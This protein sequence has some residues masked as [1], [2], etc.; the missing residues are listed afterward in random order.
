MIRETAFMAW[1]EAIELVTRFTQQQT[2]V[3]DGAQRQQDDYDIDSEPMMCE[4]EPRT[5]EVQEVPTN[6]EESTHWLMNIEPIYP[7]YEMEFDSEELGQWKTT[8]DLQSDGEIEFDE[9]W[10]ELKDDMDWGDDYTTKHAIPSHTPKVQVIESLNIP[11]VNVIV[12]EPQ[13][14]QQTP[15]NQNRQ[16]TVTITDTEQNHSNSQTYTFTQGTATETPGSRS[17]RWNRLRRHES[18]QPNRSP[19]TYRLTTAPSNGNMK[20]NRKQEQEL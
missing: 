4:A 17:N 8:A 13:R 2:A 3:R 15:P 1:K 5:M 20:G 7:Q 14:T 19:V 9:D 11:D 6:D 16:V 10:E 18:R 12:S